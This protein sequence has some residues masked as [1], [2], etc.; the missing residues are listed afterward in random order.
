M[1]NYFINSILTNIDFNHDQ[2]LY[3]TKENS[4]LHSIAKNIINFLHNVTRESYSCSSILKKKAAYKFQ[5]LKSLTYLL[6]SFAL[7]I[8]SNEYFNLN[9]LSMV[10]KYK[11]GLKKIDFEKKIEIKNIN[12]KIKV[13]S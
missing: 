1:S 13:K 4:K 2:F 12:S 6:E 5:S 10:T 3:I 8:E 7:S 9:L 11:M